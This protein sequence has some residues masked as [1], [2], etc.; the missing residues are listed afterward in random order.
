MGQY[1]DSYCTRDRITG[2]P[3][4]SHIL[5]RLYQHCLTAS[6]VCVCV[7]GALSELRGCV[8]ACGTRSGT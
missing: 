3:S 8:W 6:R 7:H 2:S 1:N 5:H 4:V